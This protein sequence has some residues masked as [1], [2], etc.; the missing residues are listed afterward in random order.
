MVSY[1]QHSG[2]VTLHSFLLP[3]LGLVLA[4]VGALIYSL[5]V[6][7]I[8]IAGFVSLALLVGYAALLGFGMGR[9]VK[10]TKC[11]NMGYLYLMA[12]LVGI[13]GYY[14]Q[15]VVFVSALIGQMEYGPGLLEGITTLLIN[16]SELWALILSINAT[17]WYSIHGYTPKEFFLWVL[18]AIEAVV[19]LVA[20]VLFAPSFIAREVFCETCGEW[21][22]VESA[23]RKAIPP[24]EE[25]LEPEQVDIESLYFLPAATE[26]A[27]PYY[28]LET[29][30]CPLCKTKQ[31]LRASRV[32][33]GQDD[34]GNPTVETKDIPKIIQLV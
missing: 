2:R 15:W 1:Y 5:G 26:D 19:I 32:T 6:V 8:P 34:K 16:P 10:L 28:L 33:H 12:I 21:N 9:L 29:L 13:F 25:Y 23:E 27:N 4:F 7:Y 30:H 22:R 14:F 20:P 24:G 3:A 18:W 31:G 11:R 17:G